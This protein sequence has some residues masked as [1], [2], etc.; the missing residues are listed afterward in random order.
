MKQLTFG[1]D[2]GGIN[3]AFGLVDEKGDVFGESVISTKKFPQF[4]DYDAYVAELCDAMHT[5][6]SSLTFEYEL[7]GIGIGAPNAN[8]HSGNIETPPNL[9]KYSADDMPASGKDE[10]IF[11]LCA[12]IKKFFPGVKKVIITN[13]ANAATLGEMVFGNAKGMRDF[14]MITLGTGLGSGFVA[15]GEMIYGHDGFAGELGHVKV[16]HGG[17]ECGCGNYG[18]L[19]AYVSATGVKRTIF[20]LMATTNKPS[21]LRSIPFCDMESATIAAAAARGDELAMETFRF[22]GEML[23]RALANMATVTSP[24]AVFLFGGLA[25]AGKLITDPTKWYLEE[26]IFPPFAGKIKILTSGIENK[27][28][29]ILGSSALIWQSL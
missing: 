23:G 22:T 20:E 29:A 3:T 24:E 14:A 19:E 15:N 4:G 10:R 5:M 6:L 27:N 26:N 21:E 18:C 17:R 9:W 11:P 28:A 1:I 2:I 7:L 12:D 25:K 16:V 13:D 8:Y